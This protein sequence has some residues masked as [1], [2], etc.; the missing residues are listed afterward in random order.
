MLNSHEQPEETHNVSHTLL[1]LILILILFTTFYFPFSSWVSFVFLCCSLVYFSFC[2]CVCF[3]K[4]KTYSDTHSTMQVGKSKK[5]SPETW[6]LFA[7]LKCWFCVC[8]S[9]LLYVIWKAFVSNSVAFLH[10]KLP[11]SNVTGLQS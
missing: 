8:L 9:N 6:L 11:C 3:F 2:L 4:Q 10:T 7:G 1:L 5:F